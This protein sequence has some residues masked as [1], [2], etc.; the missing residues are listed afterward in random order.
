MALTQTFV[1]DGSVSRSVS[2]RGEY[3]GAEFARIILFV[4]GLWV[5]D[6]F[7][8]LDFAFFRLIGDVFFAF[9]SRVAV[10]TVMNR[11][12]KSGRIMGKVTCELSSVNYIIHMSFSTHDASAMPSSARHNRFSTSLSRSVTQ[13]K[14]KRY[15]NLVFR[16]RFLRDKS[17]VAV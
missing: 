3:F 15:F 6:D 11:L 17:L 4:F 2:G 10:G 13:K 16:Q 14:P 12:Q 7:A 8:V 5:N 1:L 9:I